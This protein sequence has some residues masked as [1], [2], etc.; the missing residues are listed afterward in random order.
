MP[1]Y[2]SLIKWTAQGIH[3]VKDSPNRLDAFKQAAQSAGGRVIF[4]YML[5]GDY[6]LATLVE[7][8]DDESYARL[9][10]ATASL[11]NLRTTSYRAFTE[12]E[13]RNII[14]GLP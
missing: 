1:S 13:Y 5:V 10:L 9:A 11:G 4:F 7:M 14:A 8:P 6:D 2:L 12:A 3:N